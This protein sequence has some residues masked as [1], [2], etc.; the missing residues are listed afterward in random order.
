[1][2]WGIV[3]PR[4]KLARARGDEEDI[5]VKAGIGTYLGFHIRRIDATIDPGARERLNVNALEHRRAQSHWHEYEAEMDPSDAL[6]LE[7]EVRQYALAL[8]SLSGAAD[9]IEAV[10]KELVFEAEPAAARAL[11][12]LLDA[13]APYGVDEPTVAAGMVRHQVE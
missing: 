8:E 13:C 1:A 10:R 2:L 4:R 12:D 11:R 3:E 5:L 9:E 6:D 7:W